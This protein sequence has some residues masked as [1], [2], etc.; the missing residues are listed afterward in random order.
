MMME[1]FFL[2]SEEED[3]W[4]SAVRLNREQF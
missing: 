1:N 2:I 3:Q 4:S